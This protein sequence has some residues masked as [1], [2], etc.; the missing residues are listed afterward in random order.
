MRRA[1]WFRCDPS[2]LLGALAGMPS[3]CGYVYTVIIL[4]IYEVGGPIPDTAEVLSRRTGIPVRRV[5]AAINWLLTSAKLSLT[6]DHCFDCEKTH[7]E[8]NS[9]E[10]RL[11]VAIVAGKTSAEN[12]RQKR[13]TFQENVATNAQPSLNYKD[14]DKDIDSREANASLVNG[15]AVDLT[16]KRIERSQSDQALL[17]RITD[18]W[19]A[20]AKPRGLPAVALLTA[21]RSIHCRRRVADLQALTGDE[22]PEAAFDK[23]LAKCD[24]S[25]FIRGSP[26]SK[27]GF[28][29]LMREGF[30]ARMMENGFE[31]QERKQSWQR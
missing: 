7:Q 9:R 5:E 22:T 31:N 12:R 24:A 30:M 17:D 6:S 26:R 21:Q 14:I 23:L 20:W 19:N 29:Q 27:L 28:D 3:D 25:F 16:R 10:T 18:R 1:P 13:L 15:T 2:A 4:R 8:L 11:N